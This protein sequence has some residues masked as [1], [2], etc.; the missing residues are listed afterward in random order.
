LKDWGK[1]IYPDDRELLSAITT[2]IHRR[3]NV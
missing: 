3:G 1:L 2:A